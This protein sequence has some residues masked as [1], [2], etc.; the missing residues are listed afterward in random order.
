MRSHAGSRGLKLKQADRAALE[1]L[2]H[3]GRESVRVLKRG[4]AL[5]L[6]AEGWTV[7]GAAEAVGVTQTTV[8]TVCRRYLEEGLGAA[9]MKSPGPERRGF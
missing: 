4:R 6:L 8:R 2:T 1:A 7:V 3:R 5:Q 9:C